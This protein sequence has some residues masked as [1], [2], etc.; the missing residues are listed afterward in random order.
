MLTKHGSDRMQQRGFE[1]RAVELILAHGSRDFDHR[2]AV[3]R[4]LDR[5]KRAK[6]RTLIGEPL[7]VRLER[8]LGAVVIQAVDTGKVITI[9]HRPQ[10][11]ARLMC[12][13][14]PQ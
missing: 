14:I 8:Q 10:P 4:Y 5:R 12:T 11:Q 9:F 3:R 13:G 1:R 7:Y 2:G 6:I